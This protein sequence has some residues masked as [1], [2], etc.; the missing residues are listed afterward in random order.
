MDLVCAILRQSQTI[1]LATVGTPIK[2]ATSSRPLARRCLLQ[3]SLYDVKKIGSNVSRR[4]KHLQVET[5]LNLD[6]AQQSSAARKSLIF[7]LFYDFSSGSF[8]NLRDVMSANTLAFNMAILFFMSHCNR[9]EWCFLEQEKK[10]EAICE[11]IVS[12]CQ[13]NMFDQ[14]INLDTHFQNDSFVRRALLFKPRQIT[15]PTKERTTESPHFVW[16]VCFQNLKSINL[17]SR[18]TKLRVCIHGKVN[19]LKLLFRKKN[20]RGSA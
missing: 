5:S 7:K 2:C 11:I 15:S 6:Y 10:N 20:R 4:Q 3:N 17:N 13:Y 12:N 9:I 1:R 18:L 8:E 16:F 19:P 14:L